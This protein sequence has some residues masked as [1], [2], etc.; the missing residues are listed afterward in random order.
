MNVV[1]KF[2]ALLIVVNL[3]STLLIFSVSAVNADDTTLD[4]WED[5]DYSPFIEYK[6]GFADKEQAKTPIELKSD[7]AVLSCED[8]I[9][10]TEAGKN[11]VLLDSGD[12]DQSVNGWM[13]WQ[14]EIPE[15]RIYYPELR[16]LAAGDTG[17]NPQIRLEVDGEVPYREFSSYALSRVYK[18]GQIERDDKGN[19]GIPEQQEVKRWQAAMFYELEGFCSTPMFLYLEK[20]E[21]TLRLSALEESLLVSSLLLT[22]LPDVPS[23]VQAAKGYAEAGLKEYAPFYK[24]VQAEK[25]HEKSDSAV[26]PKYDRTSPATVPYHPTLIRR[27]IIGGTSWAT[28]GMWISYAVDDIP[29]D[30]L[31]YLSIKFRQ[32]DAV[33]VTTFRNIYINGVIPSASFADVDFPYKVDWQLKTIADSEGIPCPVYLKKGRNEIRFEVS[34]GRFSEVL[35]M[36]DNACSELRKLYT[37]MVMITGTNPDKY[38]DYYLDKEIPGLIE[39]FRKQADILQKAADLFDQISGS[40]SSE[41]EIIRDMARRLDS[42]TKNPKTI[43]KRLTSYRDGIS[44]LYSLLDNMT[45]QPLEMDYFIIHSAD[46]KLPSPKAALGARLLHHMKTFINSFVEDYNTI[47]P[48]GGKEAIKVWV[49]MGRDQIQVIRNMITEEFTPQ[50]G[51]NVRL[52]IVQTGFIEATLSGTGPDVAIGIARG[53]PVNLACRNALMSFDDYPGFKQIK[54]R[55]SDTALI[56]YQFQGKTYALPCTQTFYMLFYRRDI[57]AQLGIDVPKTWDDISRAVPK[58]QRSNM[59]IGLPYSVI[60]AAAAVDTGLGAKDMFASLLL[61]NGGKF[62]A[63]DHKSTLLDSEQAVNAFKTW[64]DY[65]TQYDFDLVY[66]FFTRFRNGEMPLGIASFEMFNTLSIGAREINGLWGMAPVPGTVREDGTVNNSVAGGGTAAVIFKKAKDTQACYKFLDWWTS[67]QAQTEFCASLESA[68]GPGG[69][70][71]TAN[72]KAFASQPWIKNQ[73][74]MLQRQRNS[75]IELPEIPG[76]YYVSRSIDNAF[77]SVLFDGKNPREIFIKENRAINREIQRKRKELGLP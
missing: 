27:N 36:V 39:S 9:Q 67:N 60:S 72:L 41:S 34:G 13:E 77:R 47:G 50:T 75:V 24:E 26:F 58:L 18:D 11:A 65:Y 4:L 35:G 43:H 16:Y 30:G 1:R 68:L 25:T 46:S 55:F 74:E 6:A 70:Y 63:D 19:D 40:K 76:S 45:N 32:K 17:K 14:F 59:G 38:R 53:Q 3:M 57:L 7:D 8:A 29:A 49:N 33:G 20:G 23:D 56:P 69:R 73:L 10:V 71:P 51:I 62:Y 37:Q 15:S 52:S 12:T 44:S 66:D 48:D 42:F 31:Y 61:Q 22:N 21:H 54:E 2:A 64:C 28:R 5:I